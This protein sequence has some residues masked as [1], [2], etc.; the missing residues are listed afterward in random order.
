M[1]PIVTALAADGAVLSVGSVAGPTLHLRLDTSDACA[2][3]VVA[4]PVLEAIV[5]G[6]LRTGAVDP[7]I[8]IERVEI[9]HVGSPGP[10]VAPDV[11]GAT[12]T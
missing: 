7:P 3:C 1:A 4:D 8:A 12:Q 9:E 10:D 6:Q 11:D 2:E 5:L